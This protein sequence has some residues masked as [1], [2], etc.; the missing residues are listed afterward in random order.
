M[1]G[2]GGGKEGRTERKQWNWKKE[3]LG[4]RKEPPSTCECKGMMQKTQP[5]RTAQEVC[6]EK[7]R[8]DEASLRLNTHHKTLC[9][10]KRK[11]VMAKGPARY[12]T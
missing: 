3:W 9:C 2:D 1:A 6:T 12:E 7:R 8:A 5:I 4:K 10:E 11:K